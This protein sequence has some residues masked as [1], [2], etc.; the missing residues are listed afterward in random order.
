MRFKIA[1]GFK[2]AMAKKPPAT[3]PGADIVNEFNKAMVKSHM[4]LIHDMIL[5]AANRPFFNADKAYPQYVV[6][7]ISEVQ[8]IK[9]E[10]ADKN[11]DELE[12]FRD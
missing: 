5:D 2:D 3:G 9:T 10:I 1:G 6:R 12:Q 4:K 11:R 8:Q 7:C